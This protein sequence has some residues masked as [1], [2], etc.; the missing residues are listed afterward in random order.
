MEGSVSN[1]S[2][3]VRP[4][5]RS[6]RAGILAGFEQLSPE[7]RYL[8]FAAPKPR[9]T[10]RDLAHL[11]D[12]DHDRHEALVAYDPVSGDPV[13]VARYVRLRDDPSTA[14]IAVTVV[15]REQGHGVGRCLVRRLVDTAA[16]HGVRVLRAET[17]SENRRAIRGLL[18]GGFS[19]VASA[20]YTSTFELRLDAADPPAGRLLS[21]RAAIRRGTGRRSANRSVSSRPR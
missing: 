6:D 21:G 17:L 12:V 4:L 8:R 16:A 14:E 3:V 9:L 2:A 10:E 7:S 20:G 18:A 19:R 5:R 15:D 11:L 1:G 13:G